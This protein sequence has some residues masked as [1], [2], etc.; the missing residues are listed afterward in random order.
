[1]IYNPTDLFRILRARVIISGVEYSVV[2]FP[3]VD[4]SLD[5]MMSTCGITLADTPPD[6]AIYSTVTIDY[7]ID[8]GLTWHRLFT[9]VLQPDQFSYAPLEYRYTVTDILYKLDTTASSDIDLSGVGYLDA[10]EDL[11]LAAGI[12]A[13][14]IDLPGAVESDVVDR[15][16][17]AEYV[18]EQGDSLQTTMQ[19]LLDFGRYR[20]Y[21]DANGVVK[22]AKYSR[23]PYENP[24]TYFST[25][26]TSSEYG[27][28]SITSHLEP[29]QDIVST[30]TVDGKGEDITG[31]W[32]T[33][34]A[35]GKGAT[36]FRNNF[37]TTV[38]QCEELAQ[39]I[40]VDE[41]RNERTYDVKMPID[42]NLAPGTC[43]KIKAPEINIGSLIPVR[44][45]K[46]SIN[47]PTM[48]LV[49][50]AGG[51]A[52]DDEG[53][54][55][56]DEEIYDPIRP[57]TA[58]FS[59]SLER[60]AA[61]YGLYLDASLSSS[62]AGDIVSYTW[63]IN[64]TTVG[65]PKPM[66]TDTAKTFVLIEDTAG[67]SVTL[68]I[69]DSEGNTAS[70]TQDIAANII[71]P[72]TRMLSAL[73]D[74]RW[75]VLITHAIGWLNVTPEGVTPYI[76]PRYQ[77]DRYFFMLATNGEL[78]RF[79]TKNAGFAPIVIGTFSAVGGHVNYHT[80]EVGEA[81]R[82]SES[83]NTLILA[84]EGFLWRSKNIL[85]PPENIT[86]YPY[87]HSE[88]VPVSAARINATKPNIVTAVFGEDIRK[89]YDD[90]VTFEEPIYDGSEEYD[91]EDTSTIY[92][93]IKPNYAQEYVAFRKEQTDLTKMFLPTYIDWSAVAPAPTNFTA[94][95]PSHFY[96]AV[97]F[98]TDTGQIYSYEYGTHILQ[99]L[100]TVP[101]DDLGNNLI[102]QILPD[103]TYEQILWLR[104]YHDTYSIA[105]LISHTELNAVFQ[106]KYYIENAEGYM[107]VHKSSLGYGPIGEHETKFTRNHIWIIPTLSDFY[108]PQTT[109]EERAAQD[110]IWRLDTSTGRWTKIIPP[111]ALCNW[112]YLKV[113]GETMFL[114][115]TIR[116]P[117]NPDSTSET[118]YFNTRSF[119]TY[120]AG[121]NW[122][123]LN[124]HQADF[125]CTCPTG[126]SGSSAAGVLQYGSTWYL[127]GKCRL[128]F[129]SMQRYYIALF[130]LSGSTW[131]WQLNVTRFG[132]TS[133][134]VA[135]CSSEIIDGNI[136]Y[137]THDGGISIFKDYYF[138]K[139]H[140][141]SGTN[142]R[143]KM[144]HYLDFD[145][146]PICFSSG[147]G[148]AKLLYYPPTSEYLF[149]AIQGG[150]SGNYWDMRSTATDYT[151]G[152]A[153]EDFVG[154]RWGH[155][156]TYDS[157]GT[158][159]AVRKASG[160]GTY[161]AGVNIYPYP[162]DEA[163]IPVTAPTTCNEYDA[164]LDDNLFNANIE[165]STD[166]TVVVLD[167]AHGRVVIRNPDTEIWS[168]IP[169]PEDVSYWPNIAP[170]IQIQEV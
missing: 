120:D 114:F 127:F 165:C 157:N 96:A 22:A 61:D 139:Y 67:V 9:G 169:F 13:G 43:I 113:S 48:N 100:I 147:Y 19:D 17:I 98:G 12:S 65:Y 6:D 119:V 45:I 163:D 69:E 14:D 92:D 140:I 128:D 11:L 56:P 34:E 97:Y 159:Y 18:V 77:D 137:R 121:N 155:D 153:D 105:K 164:G 26:P 135:Q 78:Y 111:I 52:I 93:L 57:P 129:G 15:A 31:E 95:A 99:H 103:R 141:P 89:S 91:G 117:D 5:N 115:G 38:D 33:T 50:S 110:F 68:S 126:P 36:G 76:I 29:N 90:C 107:Q 86:Y 25:Q 104:I 145:R 160:G 108:D 75:C 152:T 142:Y 30:V 59:Y 32:S 53:V 7:S 49:C 46:Q 51:R 72:M 16:T 150:L 40:G 124:Y 148:Y 132:R 42:H 21:T 47:G 82:S 73:V 28:I 84:G 4:R 54:Y 35:S 3:E 39:D 44:V 102:A 85:Y 64:G 154:E 156:Y 125:P 2:G 83:G 24:T 106:A 151:V 63:V 122:T 41:C 71:I 23:V 27:I 8:S 20:L 1:M 130:L 37:C 58:T 134:M 94:I 162:F 123:E 116:E 10:I 74:N 101:P 66:P 170:H 149:M 143:T 136:I 87:I 109:E 81:L 131:V 144:D 60:E 138:G 168:A 55:D 167:R 166:D 146:I 118:N 158:I 133:S 112:Y 88:A 79:D 161:R 62:E 80:I 70:V